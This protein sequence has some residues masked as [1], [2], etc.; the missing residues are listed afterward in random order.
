MRY[1]VLQGLLV[2]QEPLVALRRSSQILRLSHNGLFL[3]RHDDYAV[4]HLNR[5]EGGFVRSLLFCVRDRAN[6]E[7]FERMAALLDGLK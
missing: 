1:R 5:D 7:Y 2:E 3:L 4:Q 6:P